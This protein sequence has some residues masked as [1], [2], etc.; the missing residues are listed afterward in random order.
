MEWYTASEAHRRIAER[1]GDRSAATDA[2]TDH[3]RHGL[4]MA[5]ASSVVTDGEKASDQQVDLQSIAQPSSVIQW[6]WATSDLRVTNWH[7]QRREY[8][9]LEAFGVEIVKDGIDALSAMLHAPESKRTHI[10]PMGADGLPDEWARMIPQ[11]TRDRGDAAWWDW[12]EACSWVRTRSVEDLGSQWAWR[13]HIQA[14]DGA[15]TPSLLLALRG[16]G[17]EQA[18]AEHDLIAAILAEKV[19]SHGLRNSDGADMDIPATAWHDAK[20]KYPEG[21]VALGSKRDHF[22]YKFVDLLFRRED[23]QRAFPGEAILAPLQQS[24]PRKTD[25]AKLEQ[26][27]RALDD[28][29]VAKRYVKEPTIAA[30][31]DPNDGPQ[32]KVDSV[33]GLMNGAGKGGRPSSSSSNS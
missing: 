10:E 26:L 30:R 21:R 23:V 19:L 6:R 9:A 22:S 13:E 5:K 15:V 18:Q 16:V 24:Q 8:L 27:A 7:W 14:T 29:G 4:L 31:W 28:E 32:P 11:F 12:T 17:D 20:V 33:T 3:L 25:A 1:L 2:I